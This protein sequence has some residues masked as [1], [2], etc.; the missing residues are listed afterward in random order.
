[1][2]VSI[3]AKSYKE[4]QQYSSVLTVGLVVPMIVV[5]YLPPATLANLIFLPFLGPVTLIRNAIFNIW[6]LDQILIGLASSI[7]YLVI[8]IYAAVR[9]FSQEKAIF[10]I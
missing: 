9:I 3:F 8:F 5:M 1:M 7:A 4:A 2:M 6:A 10:R